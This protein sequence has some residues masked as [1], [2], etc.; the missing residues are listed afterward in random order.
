MLALGRHAQWHDEWASIVRWG[1]TPERKLQSSCSPHTRYPPIKHDALAL[2]HRGDEAAFRP[3]GGPLVAMARYCLVWAPLL[4]GMA[5]AHP[6]QS[7]MIATLATAVAVSNSAAAS[8]VDWA[9][10]PDPQKVMGCFA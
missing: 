7:V 3:N 1:G 2:A 10:T 5:F 4:V 8:R 6:L 9:T